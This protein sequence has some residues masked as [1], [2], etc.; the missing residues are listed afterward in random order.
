MRRSRTAR[1]SRAGFTLIEL[2]VVIAIIG[3][4]VAL[5]LPAV[6]QAREAANRSKC[7]NQ[8]KQLA[9][10][11]Q[12][13]HDTFQTFPSGWYCDETDVNCLPY[14][15]YPTMWSGLT[16]MLPNLEQRTLFD[17][18]NFNLPPMYIDVNGAQRVMPENATSLRRSLE[19]FVC[20]SNRKPTA[21]GGTQTTQQPGGGT[22]TAITTPRVGPS[23]YRWNMAAGRQLGCTPT[24][25]IGY[26]DCA[27]YD[28][29]IAY[30][31]ST[32]SIADIT[33]GTSF[34]IMMG[35]VR[36]GTWPDASS[37]CVRTTDEPNRTMNRPL[38][39]NN[40]QYWTY[41]SSQHSGGV[42]NF[43]RCDGSVS[44][45]HS[46]IKKPVLVK[47]MTRNGGESVTSDD[48]K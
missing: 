7:V 43:A 3:V 47:L 4:L 19:S 40:R 18:I 36:E 42:V 15:A 11:A 8:M 6:Q 33:D 24:T 12:Q 37:C 44:S 14:I 46:Q 38:I 20:P 28:N 23:D 5:I 17:E 10:A 39:A 1:R 32:V 22:K 29:G 2:L 9:L 25:G 21:T 45:L 30:R 34:T 13:Y 27:N 26:D 35:E 41:W 48:L 16:S 31:N